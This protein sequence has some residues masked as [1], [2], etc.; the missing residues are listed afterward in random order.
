[1][2]PHTYLFVPGDRPE[3]FDKAQAAGA[4]A[5]IID[6]EDAVPAERKGEAR[7]HTVAWARAHAAAL[8]AVLVRVNA[9]GSEWFGSD[10]TAMREAGDDLRQYLSRH[11]AGDWGTVDKGDARAN[12]RAGRARVGPA[13]EAGAEFEMP[14]A[15]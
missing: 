13:R 5:I 10:I 2:T 8:D 1:M 9:V 4:D 15:A 3:R 11:A 14:A 6:L 7:S 12:D